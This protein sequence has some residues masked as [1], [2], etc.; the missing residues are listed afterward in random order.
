VQNQT[1]TAWDIERF[2]VDQI[3]GAVLLNAPD[4]YDFH[5]GTLKNNSAR[6]VYTNFVFTFRAVTGFV[7]L[8]IVISLFRR[9]QK[10]IREKKTI[11]SVEA[12]AE[13]KKG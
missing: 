1:V 13:E 4:I 9:G 5:V 12:A 11:A 8:L 10:P 6:P 3:A 2:T 7:L